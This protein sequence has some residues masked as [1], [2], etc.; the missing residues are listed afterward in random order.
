MPYAHVEDRPSG[1]GASAPP[2]ASKTSQA[3]AGQP[4]LLAPTSHPDSSLGCAP[5]GFP[6]ATRRFPCFAPGGTL[7][8]TS[9]LAG[10]CTFTNIHRISPASPAHF[11]GLRSRR[12]P[13]RPYRRF[14]RLPT[15]PPAPLAR[16]HPTPPV[17]CRSTGPILHTAA[18]SRRLNAYRSP[19]PLTRFARISES[20]PF[21]L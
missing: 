14:T 21:P 17:Q 3:L 10:R 6:S 8:C 20:R 2:L 1:R 7:S 9:V 19:F 13:V 18:K 4:G 12:S 15:S 5:S 16:A 11:C